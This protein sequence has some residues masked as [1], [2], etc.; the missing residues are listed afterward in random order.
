MRKCSEDDVWRGKHGEQIVFLQN[1]VPSRRTRHGPNQGS[2]GYSI[3]GKI[4]ARS[5]GGYL[6]CRDFR[7]MRDW[8]RVV[9]LV[10]LA[11]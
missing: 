7:R 2:E 6:R 4:I 10:L 11:N 1:R 5:F 9:H 3:R 8:R